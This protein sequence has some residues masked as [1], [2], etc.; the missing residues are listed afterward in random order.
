MFKRSMAS[1]WRKK[2]SQCTGLTGRV[3]ALHHC[4]RC[5]MLSNSPA[6]LASCDSSKEILSKKRELVYTPSS[7]LVIGKIF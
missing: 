6:H 2:F 3:R 7:S 5:D 1:V 4:L